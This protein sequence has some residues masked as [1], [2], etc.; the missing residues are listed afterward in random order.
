MRFVRFGS[1]PFRIVVSQQRDDVCVGIA[2]DATSSNALLFFLLLTPPPVFFPP[3]LFFHLLKLEIGV[4]KRGGGGEREGGF[5]CGCVFAL[6]AF[7]AAATATTCLS[8]ARR[9]FLF[10]SLFE[11]YPRIVFLLFFLPLPARP[12]SVG[13]SVDRSINQTGKR[14]ASALRKR[15][16]IC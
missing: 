6:L 1:L 10:F 13:W 2:D 4:A 11:I 3:S 9:V 5:V 7:V 14:E 8:P 12:R 15:F 16:K